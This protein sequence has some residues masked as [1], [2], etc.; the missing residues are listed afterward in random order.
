M[1]HV[2]KMVTGKNI[3]NTGWSTSH[4][5]MAP[6]NL[7]TSSTKIKRVIAQWMALCIMEDGGCILTF[8][9]VTNVNIIKVALTHHV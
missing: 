5:H 9:K 4:N 1:C 7:P 3:H 6:S 8:A 2:S